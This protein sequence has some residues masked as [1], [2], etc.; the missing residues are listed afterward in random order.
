MKFYALSRIKHNGEVFEKGDTIEL[1]KNDALVVDGVVA[2]E[3]PKEPEAPVN[4]DLVIDD[5]TRKQNR[6]AK[7][8]AD[9]ATDTTSPSDTKDAEDETDEDEEEELPPYAEWSLE[10]LKAECEARELVVEGRQDRKQ[11]FVAALE[12]DDETDEDEIG[13]DL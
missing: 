8:N 4:R 5:K 3:K 2:T 11:P 13:D 6:K 12:A 10:D 7:K 1:D 9:K